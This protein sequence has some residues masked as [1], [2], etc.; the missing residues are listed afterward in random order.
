ME[1]FLNKVRAHSFFPLKLPSILNTIC[2]FHAATFDSEG[3]LDW[4]QAMVLNTLL[5]LLFVLIVVFALA[6]PTLTNSAC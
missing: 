3:Q 1:R 2:I 5:N 4:M 6:Y